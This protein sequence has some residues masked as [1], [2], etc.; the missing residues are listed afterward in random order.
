MVEY[1]VKLK[2][3]WV[4]VPMRQSHTKGKFSIYELTHQYQEI[5][6]SHKKHFRTN[7]LSSTRLCPQSDKLY[8]WHS[9]K[10]DTDTSTLKGKAE[11][12]LKQTHYL[13]PD[14]THSDNLYFRQNLSFMTDPDHL[15]SP[16]IGKAKS[17]DIKQPKKQH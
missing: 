12:I 6:G 14:Y 13:E 16:F 11:S 15:S 8:S 7:P 10:A 1:L 2:A 9:F 3:G 5:T 4:K 17:P